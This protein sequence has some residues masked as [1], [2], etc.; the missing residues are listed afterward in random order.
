[1]SIQNSLEEV[2]RDIRTKLDKED[3]AREEILRLTRRA[4]RSSA[5]SIKLLHRN[6]EEKAKKKLMN[7]RE[8]LDRLQ[9]LTDE[10]AGLHESSTLMAFQEYAEAQFLLSFIEGSKFPN[11]SDMGVPI[12]AFLLGLADFVGE[13]RRWC[14]DSVRRAETKEDLLPI[15]NVLTLMEDIH[16]MLFS[17]DYPDRLVPGLRRKTDVSRKLVETTRGTVTN[18]SLVYRK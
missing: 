2:I 4:T 16:S 11:Y 12:H 3:R 6:E 15:D 1:M 18:A 7:A 9:A 5:E 8:I 13:L 14:L 17:L 10:F